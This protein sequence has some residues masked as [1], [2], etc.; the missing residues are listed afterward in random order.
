MLQQLIDG[1]H[2][3]NSVHALMAPSHNL[4][5]QAGRFYFDMCTHV[6]SKLRYHVIPNREVLNSVEG[7]EVS[8]VKYRLNSFALD[9]VKPQTEVITWPW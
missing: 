5:L 4:M 3:Q 1:W 2:R 6:T 8:H 9:L 7:I